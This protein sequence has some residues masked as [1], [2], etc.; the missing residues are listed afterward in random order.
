MKER[1]VEEGGEG[2]GGRSEGEGSGGVERSGVEGG[3]EGR[4]VEG[5]GGVECNCITEV[6]SLQVQAVQ[7]FNLVT[8]IVTPHALNSNHIVV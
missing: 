4:G 5:R 7:V 6:F 8:N 3:V 1:G 2:S